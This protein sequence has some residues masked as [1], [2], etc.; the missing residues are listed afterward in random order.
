MVLRNNT[1]YLQPCSAQS[2]NV[3]I[4]FIKSKIPN[5]DTL[6]DSYDMVLENKITGFCTSLHKKWILSNRTFNI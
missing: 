3:L 5:W 4:G 2:K 1:K 6:E